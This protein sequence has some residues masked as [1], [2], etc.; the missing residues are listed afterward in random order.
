MI[1]LGNIIDLPI[2]LRKEKGGWAFGP[3]VGDNHVNEG[4]LGRPS[5]HDLGLGVR[6]AEIAILGRNGFDKWCVRQS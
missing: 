4:V 6:R 3:G 2:R 5:K 1:R